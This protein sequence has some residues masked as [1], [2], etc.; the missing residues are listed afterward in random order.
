MK[1]TLLA[2]LT[3]AL[4]LPMLTSAEEPDWGHLYPP[5]HAVLPFNDASSFELYI[6]DFGPGAPPVT[7]W[8]DVNGNG[9]QDPRELLASGCIAAFTGNLVGPSGNLHVEIATVFVDAST[10]NACVGTT[11]AIWGYYS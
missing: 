11:G 4:A 3:L 1:W 2:A 8:E 5:N 9:V 10:G 7:I 6:D